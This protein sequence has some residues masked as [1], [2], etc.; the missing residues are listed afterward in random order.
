MKITAYV[1][2]RSAIDQMWRQNC[3]LGGVIE[4]AK[5]VLDGSLASGEYATT[6]TL[7]PQQIEKLSLNPSIVVE[8][9]TNP[10]G[11]VEIVVDT[12]IPSTD[13]KEVIQPSGEVDI[14]VEETLDAPVEVEIKRR[15]RPR[16]GV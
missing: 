13:V 1:K 16:K 8:M 6:D 4:E 5:F 15:G 10:V 14:V 3:R 12:D 2:R 9:M 11:K 7:T